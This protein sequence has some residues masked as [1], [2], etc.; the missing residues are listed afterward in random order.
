MSTKE[1]TLKYFHSW[2]V[3]TNLEE[4]S[5]CLTEDFKIDAG[6][7]AFQDRS[8]FIQFLEVNT[9]PWKDVTL[10]HSFYSEDYA[11]ILYEGVN[12]ENLQKFRVSEHILVRA[13]L[14]A[15]VKTVIAALN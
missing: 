15:E 7:F 10:L 1:I 11:A 9:T 5:G 3:P 2:Q 8:S 14:I 13:G 12:T 4:L 6:F